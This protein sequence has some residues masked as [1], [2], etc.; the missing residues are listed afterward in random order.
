MPAKINVYKFFRCTTNN[1]HDKLFYDYHI[2]IQ[3]VQNA[4]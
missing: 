4:T 1:G 3:K 2:L